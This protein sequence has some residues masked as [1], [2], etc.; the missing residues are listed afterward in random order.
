VRNAGTSIID[1]PLEDPNDLQHKSRHFVLKAHN[2]VTEDQRIALVE[3]TVLDRVIP[4]FDGNANRLE[5]A[6]FKLPRRTM[7]EV[8]ATAAQLGKAHSQ[9]LAL[10]LKGFESRYVAQGDL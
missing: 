2:L 3:A 9:R 4:R 5:A 7:N 6:L 8:M 1:L 10:F